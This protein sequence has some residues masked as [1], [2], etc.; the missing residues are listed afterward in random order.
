MQPICLTHRCCCCADSHIK[1]CKLPRMEIKKSKLEFQTSSIQ[2]SSSSSQSRLSHCCTIQFQF[3]SFTYVHICEDPSSDERESES[4][5]G[6]KNGIFNIETAAVVRFV[7]TR[8]FAV[9]FGLNA[10]FVHS[11]RL[12]A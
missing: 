4:R 1:N 9:D 2:L 5:K 11:S 6:N 12:H 7:L 3:L 10:V 8:I